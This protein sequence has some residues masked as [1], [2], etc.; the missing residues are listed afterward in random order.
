MVRA[1]R[2]RNSDSFMDMA[3]RL[4]YE[5]IIFLD[6]KI[7]SKVSTLLISQLLLLQSDN[8]NKVIKLYINSP[9]GSVYDGLGIYDTIQHIKCPVHTFCVGLA[10]SMASILLA[11]GEKGHRYCLPNSK[12][13]VHQPLGQYSVIINK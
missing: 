2:I 5:R 4:F 8:P 11:S 13:M 1:P 9:G 3:T 7:D 10:A 12:I 6:S